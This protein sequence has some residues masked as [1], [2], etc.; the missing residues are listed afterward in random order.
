MLGEVESQAIL[1]SSVI[2]VH[3]WKTPWSDWLCMMMLESYV[4]KDKKSEWHKFTN[5][6]HQL[7]WWMLYWCKNGK[8]RTAM[9]VIK[10]K[11]EILI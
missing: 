4:Q 11:D 7:S 2:A 1:Q 10:P 9:I 5:Y 8:I 3:S 6:Y